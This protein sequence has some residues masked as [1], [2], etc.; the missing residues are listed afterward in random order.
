M[1]PEM[2]VAHLDGPIAC[3][4]P[5]HLDGLLLAGRERRDGLDLDTPLDCLAVRDGVYQAS[6]SIFVTSDTLGVRATEIG[7]VWGVR[8]G[9]SDVMRTVDTDFNID[10]MSPVK[11]RLRKQAVIEGVVAVAW[12]LNGDID[13]VMDLMAHITNVGGS[14]GTGRGGIRRYE[15]VEGFEADPRSVGLVADGRVVRNLPVGIARDLLGAGFP[16]AVELARLAPPY[17]DVTE[18]VDCVVPA[19]HEL[20]VTDDMLAHVGRGGLDGRVADAA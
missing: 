14:H 20:V 17:W 19:I 9:D 15:V 13:E 3:K 1:R 10:A 8:I 18:R 6:A 7:R 16:G 5:I 11:Q 4:R 12:Q 2:L